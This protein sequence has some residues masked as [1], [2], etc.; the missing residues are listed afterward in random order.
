MAAASASAW[1]GLRRYTVAWYGLDILGVALI[2][3][4]TMHDTQIRLNDLFNPRLYNALILLG[5]SACVIRTVTVRAERSAWLA[6]T[7]GVGAWAVGELLYD[8]A[9]SGAPPYPSVA[10]AFYLA[11][12][13][14]CYVALLLLLRARLS[15]FNRSIWLD[16]LMATLA[17][18]ALGA[19]VLFETVLNTT[20]G[21]TGV[22]VTNLAYPLG[23]IL[24]LSAVV[25][26]FALTGWRPDRTWILLGAGLVASAIADAIYLYQ[27]ATNSYTEGTIL[28]AM[29]PA[30]L[31]LLCAA[32][33]HVR[34]TWRWRSRVGRC[35]RRRLFA[36]SSV[37]ASSATTTSP[38]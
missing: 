31:L 4:H 38:A 6:F 19:A 9:Y 20:D 1:P 30:S 3:Q 34:S 16:G 21:S 18:S 12:Y 15:E 37:S 32:A 36:V 7:L 23:D 8:F 24:L 11:F 5:L 22:I 2:T 27:T 26:I 13:P 14:A 17:T 10:D 25:G 35:S 29:W 28:D 33:W